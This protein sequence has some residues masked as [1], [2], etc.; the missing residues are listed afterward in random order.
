MSEEKNIQP[1]SSKPQASSDLPTGQAGKQKHPSDETHSP[2]PATSNQQPAFAEASAD[3]PATENM[4][5]HAHHLHKAPGHGLKHYLF[6]FLMLSS[7]CSADFL[8]SINWNIKLKRTKKDNT[9]NPL[10]K[11]CLLIRSICVRQLR[12]FIIGT[13]IWIRCFQYFPD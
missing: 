13:K 12:I 3:K 8:P 9:Y 6:E 4:E 5:T 2:K 10:L 11:T 1:G 7:L